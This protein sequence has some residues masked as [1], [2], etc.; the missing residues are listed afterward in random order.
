MSGPELSGVGPDA[1][2]PGAPG[3]TPSRP[4]YYQGEHCTLCQAP[5]ARKVEEVIFDTDPRHGRH[6]PFTAYL[7]QRCFDRVMG[8]PPDDIS[9]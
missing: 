2:S 1:P 6:H 4:A 9:R 3:T 7:C 8:R 5:A